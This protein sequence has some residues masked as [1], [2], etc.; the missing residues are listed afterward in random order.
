M[1]LWLAVLALCVRLL[2]PLGHDH[3]AH[4]AHDHTHAGGHCLH[5]VVAPTTCSCG[6]HTTPAA[7]TC[8]ADERTH[9]GS[10]WACDF[11]HGTPGAMPLRAVLV[12]GAHTLRAPPP[13]V[14]ARP[15]PDGRPDHDRARA[16]PH[17]TAA[18]S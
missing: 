10:C 8:G 2:V 12:P 3:A 16:P 7:P 9:A 11:E 15:L 4:A 18:C 1:P 14:A 13:A 6:G 17:A 5:T